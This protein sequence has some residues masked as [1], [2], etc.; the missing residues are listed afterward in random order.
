MNHL[1]LNLDKLHT[2]EMGVDRIKRNL[3]L[4]VPDVVKWCYEK[5]K[6]VDAIIERKVKN[7]YVLVDGCKITV[8]AHSYTIITAHKVTK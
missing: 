4:D 6:S 1:I 8:N 5:I 3:H 2:T 7:W